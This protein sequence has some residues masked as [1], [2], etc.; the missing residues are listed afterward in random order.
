MSKPYYEASEKPVKNTPS[1]IVSPDEKKAQRQHNE[2]RFI[3]A[4]ITPET[5]RV[6]APK[7][8]W[9]KK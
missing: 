9:W 8:P 4:F 6:E 2:N 1:K 7:K 5:E 3:S